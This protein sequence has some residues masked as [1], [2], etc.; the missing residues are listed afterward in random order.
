MRDLSGAGKWGNDQSGVL[1]L[2]DSFSP[3]L[4]FNEEKV[5][6][7]WMETRNLPL[8]RKLGR[9]PIFAVSREVHSEPFYRSLEGMLD[10]LV[11]VRTLEHDDEIKNMLRIR[12]LKSQP[13]DSHWHEIRVSS[14]GEA[15]LLP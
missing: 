4:R 11:E 6:L 5:F 7:E 1:A 3:F 9:T 8:H 2:C 15:S 14:T 12:N 13:H 10:G